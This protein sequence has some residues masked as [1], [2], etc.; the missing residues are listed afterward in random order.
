[1]AKYYIPTALKLIVF[2][3]ANRCCEYCR[4][5]ADF[6]TELFSIEHILPI[7]KDGLHD[8]LNF[9]LACIGCN[10]F[11]SDKTEFLDPVSQLISP[12][13]NPRTMMWAEHFMWDDTLT[14]IVGK[15][16]IGRA[17]ITALK[18]NRPQI[19]NLRRALLAIGEH[20]PKS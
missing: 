1:M 14:S 4:C 12:L 19:K 18:L 2:A 10:I 5:P 20:P 9:A 7:A 6:T 8:L 3:R 17:T 15:T 13:Y 11:K 16:A